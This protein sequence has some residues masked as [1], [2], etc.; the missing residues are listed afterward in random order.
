MPP[1]STDLIIILTWVHFSMNTI[2]PGMGIPQINK[3]EPRHDDVIKWKHFPRYWPFVRGIHRSPV[4]SP[5]KG[6]WRGALMCSLICAWING[7]VNNRAAGDMRRHCAHYYVIVVYHICN[8]SW[9]ISKTLRLYRK[10]SWLSNHD[11][12]VQIGVWSWKL[13]V[14][15]IDKIA[16][17][18][19]LLAKGIGLCVHNIL[20][21]M[22]TGVF[23][24]VL[25]WCGNVFYQ[26]LWRHSEIYGQIYLLN[27]P[28]IYHIYG[29]VQDCSIS[30]ANTM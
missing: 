29:L 24:V 6:Q 9:Q 17:F 26:Y 13:T 18:T 11:N 21:I 19:S 14:Q 23:T 15:K 16:V 30:I 5:H 10:S 1:C 25:C 27:Q 3:E 4:N 12:S 2:H 20:S 22:H 7:W 8:G 28:S